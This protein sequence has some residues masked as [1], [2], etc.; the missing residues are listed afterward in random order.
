MVQDLISVAYPVEL[1]IRLRAL[2][3]PVQKLYDD[4]FVIEPDARAALEEFVVS[5]EPFSPV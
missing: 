5:C 2:V 1:G 3:Y 4:E